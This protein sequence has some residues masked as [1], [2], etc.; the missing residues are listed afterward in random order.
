MS[1]NLWLLPRRKD[2]VIATL[3]AG[4]SLAAFETVHAHAQR[5]DHAR[6][7]FGLSLGL[8]LA[9]SLAIGIVAA[10]VSR[11]TVLALAL[12]TLATDPD[13]SAAWRRDR[14]AH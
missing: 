11:G 7:Y 9:L 14:T 10:I 1:T 13:Y 6:E 2:A 4:F 3:A 8:T 5:W 12:W